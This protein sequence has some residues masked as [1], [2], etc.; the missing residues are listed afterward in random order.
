MAIA[1]TTPA[2]SPF[3][4]ICNATSADASSGTEVIKAATAGK[5]IR[6]RTVSFHNLTAGALEFTLIGAAALIGPVAVPA[7][8]S[9]SWTFNPLMDVGVAQALTC[10]VDAGAMCIF[11]T[12]GVS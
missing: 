5:S 1:V 8:G 10:D 12:G 11:V 6:I 2:V 9:L 4:F 7:Y 3:G